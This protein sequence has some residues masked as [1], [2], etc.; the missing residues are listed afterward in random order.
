MYALSTNLA[1]IVIHE[2]DSKYPHMHFFKWQDPSNKDIR[3]ESMKVL[4]KHWSNFFIQDLYWY[5]KFENFKYL[6]S[7]V[8][9]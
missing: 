1:S 6:E 2:I 3:Y 5:R 4:I 9:V 8:K 7:G